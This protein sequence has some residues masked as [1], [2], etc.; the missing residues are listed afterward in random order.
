MIG[1]SFMTTCPRPRISMVVI[2]RNE[3]DSLCKT[4][5]NLQS[6]LPPE[7]EIVLVDDGSEDGS[8][9]QVRHRHG[10]R[11]V[12]ST[13]VG[14]AR[15]RNLGGQHATGDVIVFS[16]AHIEAPDH[17]WQPFL[18]CLAH[19]QVGA[20]APG[21]CSF[22]DRRMCGFGL[23]FTDAEMRSGWLSK[24]SRTPY[25]VPILP[26]CF[27]AMR[28]EVFAATQGFDPGMRCLGGNDGEISLRL[29]LL[30]YELWV[31]PEVEVAHLFR[32]KAP[33][34]ADWSNVVHNRLRTALVHLSAERIAKVAQAL[35]AYEAF[36]AGFAM[37]AGGDATER[38][39]M[40]EQQRRHEDSWFFTKFDVQW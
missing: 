19:P 29:W 25:A 15:A 39:R 38:R 18:E 2:S 1:L 7:S 37:L 4:I 9:E 34:A 3:G 10:I 8:T 35:R 22:D 31:V 11:F 33:Y 6:T 12:Q 36:P 14:V 40:L 28:Q 27:L 30:G 32:K 21:V 23:H 26:G 17:W 5:D 13:G 24:K 16:D 20:V